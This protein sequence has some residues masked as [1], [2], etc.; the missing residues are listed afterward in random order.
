V[1]HHCPNTPL[2]LVGTKLD[3]REDTETINRLREKNL[4]PVSFEQGMQKQKEINAVKYECAVM[5]CANVRDA[6]CACACCRYMECSALT[7]KGLK[8]VFDEA[9][10]AV[11]NPPV[12]KKGKKKG[13]CATL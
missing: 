12:T 3:L 5:L 11:L 2:L 13:N 1:S 6:A 8:Q 9:I 4:A 10:R 7:Q